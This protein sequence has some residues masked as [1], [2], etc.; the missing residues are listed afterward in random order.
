MGFDVG[1]VVALRPESELGH[2]AGVGLGGGT[3]LADERE[4]AREGEGGPGG[5]EVGEGDSDGAGFTHCAEEVVRCSWRKFEGRRGYE[6]CGGKG[7]FARR[8]RGN[9]RER[10]GEWQSKFFDDS[11]LD[12]P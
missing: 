7:K 9:R 4:G 6:E 3:G 5:E 12:L 10:R 1:D 2:E 11:I 8:K